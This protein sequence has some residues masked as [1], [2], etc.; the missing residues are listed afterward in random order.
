[1]A[2]AL[3]RLCLLVSTQLALCSLTQQVWPNGAFAPPAAAV[4]SVVASVALAGGLAP[5]TTV[6]WTG[7]IA[8][9]AAQLVQFSAQAS[10]GVRLWVDDR[11]TI[12]D[13][14]ATQGAHVARAYLKVPFNA[15]VPQAFRLEY[16]FWGAGG[17]AACSLQWEG[18]ATALQPVPASAFAPDVSPAEVERVALRNRLVNPAVRWQTYQNPTMGA[19]VLMPA[20]LIVDATLA[21]SAGGHE[22]GDI[23]VFRQSSPALSLA[24]LHSANGSDYTQLSLSRWGAR[25]CDVSLETTVVNGDLQFLATPSGA[26]CA[27]LRLLL[28]LRMQQ[29]RPGALMLGGDGA[30]MVA[31]LPGFGN[32]T[33]HA[34]GAAPVPFV[35]ASGS[36]Y[37]ALPLAGVVGYATDAGVAP[38]PAV[39][40]NIAA[41]AAA[42]NAS[43]GI[44]GDLGEVY[45]ALSSVLYWNTM[46][47]PYEGVVTP[48]C[49]KFTTLHRGRVVYPTS[50]HPR[51]LPPLHRCPVGGISAAAMLS[52][53]RAPAAPDFTLTALPQRLRVTTYISARH[54]QTRD[55]QFP[56]ILPP[57]QTGTI[58]SSVRPL[59]SLCL[60]FPVSRLASFQRDTNSLFPTFSRLHGISGHVWRGRRR[61]AQRHCVCQHHPNHPG[62]DRPRLRAQLCLWHWRVL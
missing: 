28:R 27:R 15:S 9:P 17:T 52:L 35:N 34:L 12:D 43:A 11:L 59:S 38:V 49:C 24:G 37:L 31:V 48:V 36:V 47:T 45:E 25:A 22:L 26:D 40:A 23:I 6:R 1:M 20:G 13:G 61:Q 53:V 14:D 16:S 5:F 21:D 56:S 4:T 19:H 51:P 42:A 30:S 8:S 60:P 18:N 10:G 44:Y 46:F 41:A 50:L 2:A 58:C 62:A 33:V 32:V 54:A 29:E 55:P 57:P 7:T 39:Q 3:L